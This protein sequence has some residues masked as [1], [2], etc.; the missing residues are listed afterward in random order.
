MIRLLPLALLALLLI[1]SG[2]QAACGVAPAR[3]VYET[4]SM[5]AYVVKQKLI[6]CYRATGKAVGAGQSFNDG[7]GTD[8]SYSVV[9]VL[10]GRWLHVLFSASAGES[11]DVRQDTVIDL[12]TRHTATA[13]VFDDETDNDVVVVPGAVVTA[14]DGGVIAQFTGGRSQVL[15]RDSGVSVAASGGRIYWRDEDTGATHTATLDLPAADPARALPRART[16]GRCK[17]R[18]G[19]RLV[20]RDT[21]LVVT[22]AGGADV[23]VPAREDAAGRDRRRR[24]D[25]VRPRGGLQ[26]GRGSR[27]ARRR[28][29]Q[30]ARAGE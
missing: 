12:R 25:P 19:A 6:A 3:A 5:Q 11:S 30:A 20:V 29:R 16:I 28:Q 1:P 4:P 14:G 9:D 26:R 10:G 15:T 7:M 23:G 22:R 13:N 24:V 18:P 21:N 17:P 8:G 2:A 27:G